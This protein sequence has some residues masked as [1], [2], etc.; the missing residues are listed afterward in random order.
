MGRTLNHFCVEGVNGQNGLL[1]V[2]YHY[3]GR[4]AGTTDIEITDP[5]KGIVSFSLAT[6]DDALRLAQYLQEEVEFKAPRNIRVPSFETTSYALKI[7]SNGNVV[8]TLREREVFSKGI[9]AFS[10][11]TFKKAFPQY[12]ADDYYFVLYGLKENGMADETVERIVE[13]SIKYQSAVLVSGDLR[14]CRPMTQMDIAGITG[15]D[16]TTVS[17]AVK[18]V[19]IFTSHRNYSLDTASFSLELP[20]LFNEGILAENGEKISTL[21]IKVKIYALIEMEDKAHPLTDEQIADE[22]N[23]FGYKI[24]R[25]TV[26]KY[27]DKVLGIPGCWDRRIKE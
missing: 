13:A 7:V 4:N 11:N 27:R 10:Y 23:R 21:G 24:A 17:R 5:K 18:D 3:R 8:K 2:T 19:R 20:S 1:T 14:V 26:N 6:A 15:F 16:N 9:D 25:R 12:A 22:L